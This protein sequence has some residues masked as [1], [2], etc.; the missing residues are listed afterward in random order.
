MNSKTL[1]NN[2]FFEYS[3]ICIIII[4]FFTTVLKVNLGHI[5]SLIVI[6]LVLWYLTT[7]R[8][9]E[10]I[11][12]N[13]ELE[14]K[15][16]IIGD[17]SFTPLNFHLD[18]NLI[19]LYYNIKLNFYEYN[20]EAYINSLYA[21]D[22]LLNIR[23]QFELNLCPE[24]TP[25][26][27]L[28]NNNRDNIVVGDIVCNEMPLNAYSLYIIASDKLK[29]AMNEI[30]SIIIVLPSTPLLHYQ[31]KETCDRLHLLLKRNMD[32]IYNVYQTKKKIGDLA[33]TD[34]DGQIPMNMYT[35]LTGIN[36]NEMN[37]QFNF[38]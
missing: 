22:I 32:I 29:E 35:G 11:D 33:I 8:I 2:T 31:H 14:Y 1:D 21:T 16:G 15:M 7:T 5:L 10:N 9:K 24:P 34:Y 18:A 37:N 3:I 20:K 30:Q 6:L 27:T 4:Y 26:N 23:G 28:D 19:N 25:L 38:Y 36:D 17:E 12:L 13:S